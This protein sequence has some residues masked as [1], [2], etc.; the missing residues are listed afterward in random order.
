[1]A[2]AELAKAVGWIDALAVVGGQVIAARKAGGALVLACL[3]PEWP[4]PC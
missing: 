2:C 3:A 4:P 1:M